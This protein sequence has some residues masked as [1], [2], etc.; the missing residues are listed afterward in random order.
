MASGWLTSPRRY[1]G[2][3]WGVLAYNVATSAWGAY[4]RASGSGA[5]CGNHWPLCNGQVLP[6]SP[7]VE[8]LIELTHRSTAGIASLLVLAL[9][10][11]AFR[12]YP[13]GHPVRTG[14]VASTA[15]IVCEALMGAALVK[16]G[17]VKDDASPGRA[18]AMGLH[19][20]ITFFL[21][22]ALTVTAYAARPASE[23][24]SRRPR[25]PV[26]WS[27]AAPFALLVAAATTGAIAAL[28]DTLFHAQ[29][30]SEGMAQDASATAHLF[31]RLRALHPVFAGLAAVAVLASASV[32]VAMRPSP[33][34]V[35][36]ARVVRVVV[37]AQVAA[38]V[39]NLLLLA[40]IALQIVHLVL[41]DSLWIVL[42]VLG[43]AALGAGDEPQRAAD[44][45]TPPLRSPAL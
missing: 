28:G 3:A 44:V 31:L 29:T 18:V 39:M 14:A 2:F 36:A 30:L 7:T 10:V 1:A 23:P 13:K 42:V 16:L 15:M 4:V 26:L 20:V 6:V 12:A 8:L 43:L 19:L 17:L 45:T 40:P 11:W 22:A 21:L 38:G 37:T 35:R 34:V 33:Q 24:A 5:G 25:S 27:L 32:V 41:A 9:L